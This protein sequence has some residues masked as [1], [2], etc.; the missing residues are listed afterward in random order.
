MPIYSEFLQQQCY[1][2][3]CT[4]INT[5][6]IQKLPSSTTKIT[7]ENQIH[8]LENSKKQ[9]QKDTSKSFFVLAELTHSQN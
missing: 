6:S 4:S 7:I 3:A 1:N 8:I 9:R 2:S 5:D